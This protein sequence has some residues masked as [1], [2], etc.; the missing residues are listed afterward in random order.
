M[1]K[2]SINKIGAELHDTMKN[3]EGVIS[4]SWQYV[5]KIQHS[6]YEGIRD[7]DSVYELHMKMQAALAL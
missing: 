3:L 7:L 6:A 2:V 4:N 5:H 1:S